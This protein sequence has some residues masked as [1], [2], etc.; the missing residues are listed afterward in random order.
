MLF[1]IRATQTGMRNVVGCCFKRVPK[2]PP[3]CSAAGADMCDPLSS[4][5]WQGRDPCGL[6]PIGSSGWWSSGSKSCLKSK[7]LAWS[8]VVNPAPARDGHASITCQT[9]TGTCGRAAIV[10]AARIFFFFFFG[11][12]WKTQLCEHPHFGSLGDNPGNV[13]SCI[14]YRTTKR[15]RINLN[16]LQ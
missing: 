1:W 14:K 12:N 13:C 16:L 15:Q 4:L 6:P 9:R 7:S 10:P 2:R 11:K 3:A 8:S 5:G